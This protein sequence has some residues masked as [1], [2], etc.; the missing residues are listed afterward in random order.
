MS[1]LTAIVTW[2]ESVA[3][4]S[5]GTRSASARS[6]PWTVVTNGRRVTR[7]TMPG[8]QP[9]AVH[10]VGAARVP[11]GRDGERAAPNGGSSASRR[12]STERL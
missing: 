5:A 11:R 8:R 4:T 1:S 2:L 3:R 10:D 7:A 9:V 12:R 6:E